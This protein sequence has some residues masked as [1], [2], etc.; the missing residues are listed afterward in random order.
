[1][2]KDRALAICAFFERRIGKTEAFEEIREIF[3]IAKSLHKPVRREH[4]SS[5]SQKKAVDEIH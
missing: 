3:A 4:K 1:V 5:N 2:Q